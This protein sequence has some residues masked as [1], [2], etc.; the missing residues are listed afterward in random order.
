MELRERA[1][2]A[3]CSYRRYELGYQQRVNENGGLFAWGFSKDAHNRLAAVLLTC[4]YGVSGAISAMKQLG[5]SPPGKTSLYDWHDRFVAAGCNF[6]ALLPNAH[7]SGTHHG[8][9]KLRSRLHIAWILAMRT[10]HPKAYLREIAA[11]FHA[12][13][14]EPIHLCTVLRISERWGL[15]RKIVE[16]HAVLKFTP[17]NMCWYAKIQLLQKSGFDAKNVVIIDEVCKVCSNA[18]DIQRLPRECTAV[19]CTSHV[20]SKPVCFLV[21]ALT[22]LC[23]NLLLTRR[24]ATLVCR[25]ALQCCEPHCVPCTAGNDSQRGRQA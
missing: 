24:A 5:L 17:D 19:S 23:C 22:T 11:A 18:T 3:Q 4:A 16:P 13:W 20:L 7:G 6:V 10:L 15:C 8:G 21:Q 14:G 9:P 2:A 25:A 12:V 1:N